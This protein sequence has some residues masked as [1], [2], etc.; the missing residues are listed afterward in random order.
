MSQI[1]VARNVDGIVMACENRAIALDEK[2]NEIPLQMNRLL[3]LTPHAALLI[4]GS[5]EGRDMA[6]GLKNF[7]TGE[8]LNDVQEVYGTAMAYLSTEYER[9]MRKKC[10]ML[11]I[12][13]IHQVSFV[14]AGKTEKDPNMPFRLYYLWTKKKLPQ[15]DGD[16]IS[17][18]FSLPRRMSLEF[19]L[20][21]MCKENA[22]LKDI[23]GKMTDG[24]EHLKNKG[25]VIGP[26][27]FAMITREGYQSLNP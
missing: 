27:S 16:E 24:M 13:P 11:P 22:P 1:I 9:F 20:N 19:R 14:L 25:E 18:A 23:L 17:N 26:F 15:L 8:K 5:A 12:D 3:P 4:S 7:L 10:E 2:G 21:K 6:S